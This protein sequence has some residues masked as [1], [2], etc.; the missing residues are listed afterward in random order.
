MAARFDMV[1]GLLEDMNAKMAQVKYF[2]TQF[3]NSSSNCSLW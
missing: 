2:Q 3:L 1:E